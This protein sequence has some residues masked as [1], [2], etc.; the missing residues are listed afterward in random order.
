MPATFNEL[1]KVQKRVQRALDTL[2]RED[3]EKVLA[4]VLALYG[5][6]LK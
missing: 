2:S 4:A 6:E 3:A 5:K 1:H